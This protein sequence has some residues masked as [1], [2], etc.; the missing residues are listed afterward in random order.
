MNLNDFENHAFSHGFVFGKHLQQ[1][2]LTDDFL[3]FINSDPAKF[4]PFYIDCYNKGFNA[5]FADSGWDY[6]DDDFSDLYNDF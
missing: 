1:I 3:N 5:G 4:L 2:Q 6:P